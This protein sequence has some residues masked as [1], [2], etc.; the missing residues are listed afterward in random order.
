VCLDTEPASVRAESFGCLLGLVLRHM[1]QSASEHYRLARDWAAAGDTLSR[2]DADLRGEVLKRPRLCGSRKY[3]ARESMTAAPI[4]SIAFIW[5]R[6]A[7]SPAAS[8][9]HAAC[10]AVQEP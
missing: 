6:A 7:L 5:R 8:F 3:S 4:P 1:L 9:T 10:K 2:A